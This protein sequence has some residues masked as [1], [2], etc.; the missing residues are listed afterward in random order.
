MA[1]N[2][3]IVDMFDEIVDNSRETGI[4]SSFSESSGTYTITSSNTLKDGWHVTISSVNYTISN[5]SSTGFTIS[6]EESL[7]F[8][9]ASWK[10]LEPY[11][12]YGHIVDILQ[13]LTSKDQNDDYKFQKYPLVALLLDISESH[14]QELNYEYEFPC[15][16][17]ILDT[18]D[19]NY[20]SQERY[21]NVFKN[22]LY[23]IYETLIEKIKRYPKFDFRPT[24]LV[25]HTKSDRVYWG[26]EGTFGNV[27]IQ[28]NDYLD[29]IDLTFE[30]IKVD[31]YPSTCQ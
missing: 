5:V 17:L 1:D 28:F 16:I 14:E 31:K 9:G 13:K 23:P 30:P 10:A 11:Y 22:T 25:P 21:T 6:G 24:M 19:K 7:D 2:K 12:D 4:V 15:R 18:T 29:G 27:G 3:Y 20:T 8:T 26:S